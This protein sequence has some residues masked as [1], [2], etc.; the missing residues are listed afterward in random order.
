M[1]LYLEFFQSRAKIAVYF[2]NILGRVT[3]VRQRIDIK[4]KSQVSNLLKGHACTTVSKLGNQI[5]DEKINNVGYSSSFFTKLCNFFIENVINWINI[6]A[7]N[8]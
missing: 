4:F 5:F 2:L 6:I 3:G 8:F 1:P 7:Y